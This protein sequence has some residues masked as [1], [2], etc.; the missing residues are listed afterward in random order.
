MKKLFSMTIYTERPSAT[1]EEEEKKNYG[2]NS[3][4]KSSHKFFLGQEFTVHTYY[5]VLQGRLLSLRIIY[6]P[7]SP[8]DD[9]N[10]FCKRSLSDCFSR[11]V[12]IFWSCED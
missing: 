11:I 5:Y 6:S 12:F 2:E 9:K 3:A 10:R 7:S 4:F 8:K 1:N